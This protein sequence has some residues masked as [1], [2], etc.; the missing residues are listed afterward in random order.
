MNI[1]EMLKKHPENVDD[2]YNRFEQALNSKSQITYESFKEILG[3]YD[4][5]DVKTTNATEIR[6]GFSREE[7]GIN[8]ELR[9]K[10]PKKN[11]LDQRPGFWVHGVVNIIYRKKPNKNQRFKIY[12]HEYENQQ[13][14][15]TIK[16]RRIITPLL[17]NP[18]LA[19]VKFDQKT[20]KR[21]W[22]KKDIRSRIETEY[23]VDTKQIIEAINQK[24]MDAFRSGFE[25]LKV[26]SSSNPM[27]QQQEEK[28]KVLK[29]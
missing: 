10:N 2:I 22:F 17:D 25:I 19:Y 16:T 11:S 14:G 7:L 15:S 20:Y 3:L 29:R 9:K 12:C 6:T 27:D 24:N 26:L 5:S 23:L 4:S 21:I 8:Y 13:N 1:L 28:Q 18:E